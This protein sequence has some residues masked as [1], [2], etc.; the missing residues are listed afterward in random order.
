M[1]LASIAEDLLVFTF[2]HFA[3]ILIAS[4]RNFGARSPCQMFA[5]VRTRSLGGKLYLAS[6]KMNS[7]PSSGTE[8]LQRNGILGFIIPS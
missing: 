8:I 3:L 4:F 1:S 2:L 6:S 5:L 7:L